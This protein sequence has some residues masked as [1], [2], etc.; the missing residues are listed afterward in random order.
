M[1]F[2]LTECTHSHGINIRY[3]GLIY[4]HLLSLRGDLMQKS[5]LALLIVEMY[6]RTIKSI[7]RRKLR[8]KMK[9]CFCFLILIFI[10]LINY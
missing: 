8:D 4:Y 5:A 10:I 7:L 1:N 3:L 6:A 9:V 2:R